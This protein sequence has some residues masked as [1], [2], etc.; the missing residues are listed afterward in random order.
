MWGIFAHKR[1]I[2][3]FRACSG[4]DCRST[5]CLV[6]MTIISCLDLSF[7]ECPPSCEFLH[8]FVMYTKIQ[9]DNLIKRK[10]IN[11]SYVNKIDV[12]NISNEVCY[13]RCCRTRE[14]CVSGLV[15]ESCCAFENPN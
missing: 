7:L 5:E 6:V 8:L 9:P 13:S 3:G 15:S 11:Y 1:A 14:L 10:D 12:E 2:S 4:D